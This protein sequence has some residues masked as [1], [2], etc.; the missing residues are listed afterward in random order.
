MRREPHENVAT[1]LVD[2]CVLADLELDCLTR[3]LRLWRVVTAPV[4]VDGPRTAFQIRRRLLEAQRGAWDLAAD[5]TPVWIGFGRSWERGRFASPA[6]RDTLMDAGILAETLETATTWAGLPALKSAVTTA[7]VDALT[8]TGT[9]PI[10][11]CHISH[12]Y[13]AGASL[14]FTV[15]AALT[16]DPLA[17]WEGAKDAA[18]RAIM[19]AEGTITHHHAVGRDHRDH[20]EAEIGPLGVEILRAVKAVVDPAG[21]MN[22]DALIPPG[23]GDSAARCARPSTAGPQG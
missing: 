22:P 7:L 6:L 23:G 12:V 21:I 2:P 1:V 3:D 10:V 9:R 16:A 4:V 19:D 11:M 14:Y 15:V 13:P 20:L 17:Q 8:R 5:W 18:S